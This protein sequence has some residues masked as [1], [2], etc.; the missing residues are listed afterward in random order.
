MDELPKEVL[1]LVF[2]TLGAQDLLHVTGMS[3]CTSRCC[4]RSYSQQSQSLCLP[5]ETCTSWR[6]VVSGRLAI[7]LA[8]LNNKT[9]SNFT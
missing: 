2:L 8:G 3:R 7:N 9:L 6:E 5:P 1:E 4:F